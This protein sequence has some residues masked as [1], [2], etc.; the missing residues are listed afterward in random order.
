MARFDGSRLGQRK[1][2]CE[3]DKIR[4]LVLSF[5][6]IDRIENLQPFTDLRELHLENNNISK[7]GG[8]ESN[9]VLSVLNLR[10]NSIEVTEILC[11]KYKIL[12]I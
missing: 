11:R 6:H 7:L 12:G 3:V 8:V 2:V 10:N 4:C 1:N 9:K 5:N